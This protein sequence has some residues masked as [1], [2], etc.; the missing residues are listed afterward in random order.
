[1]YQIDAQS[2]PFVVRNSLAK[3]NRNQG[4]KCFRSTRG[5][6]SQ[7]AWLDGDAGQQN[8]WGLT[9]NQTASSVGLACSS[10]GNY[11]RLIVFE[12]RARYL[13]DPERHCV[14]RGDL[15]GDQEL[16]QQKELDLLRRHSA[17]SLG[18]FRG[19]EREMEIEGAF[20]LVD[21]QEAL[22][23]ARRDP[24]LSLISLVE[25]QE[26][27][28][29]AANIA[30][31]RQ[32]SLAADIHFIYKQHSLSSPPASLF[33]LRSANPDMPRTCHMS[34]EL[35]PHVALDLRTG[36]GKGKALGP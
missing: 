24:S 35:A 8:G 28:G 23:K 34:H 33:R 18:R 29:I 2:W 3:V 19:I 4:I 9:D 11:E 21:K 26:R 1:L 5:L 27:T 6:V 17:K 31:T 36:S 32:I 10:G 15:E 16:L 20:A 12:N 25:R 7:L 22:A 14:V 30:A 13:A